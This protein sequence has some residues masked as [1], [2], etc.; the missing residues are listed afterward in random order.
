MTESLDGD[1]F[2]SAELLNYTFPPLI[3]V[4]Q[5]VLEEGTTEGNVCVWNGASKSVRTL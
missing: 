2:L 5:T 4:T 3:A 1:I